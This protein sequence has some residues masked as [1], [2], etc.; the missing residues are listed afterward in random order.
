AALC[1][2]A[3]DGLFELLENR[4]VLRPEA[5]Q[6]LALAP[7]VDHGLVLAGVA[8]HR[9]RLL[10]ALDALHLLEQ[11]SSVE[12][13]APV[14]ARQML[15]RAVGDRTLADPAGHVLRRNIIGDDLAVVVEQ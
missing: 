14:A 2:A 6:A 8:D 15:L 3:A 11:H 13:H 12:D 9:H 4:L 10:A 5:L 1:L 7:D